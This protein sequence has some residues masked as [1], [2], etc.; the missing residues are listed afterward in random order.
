MA[1]IASTKIIFPGACRGGIAPTNFQ[2]YGITADQ[3]SNMQ[4]A[5][6]KITVA[7]MASAA[8][9]QQ[10]T[11]AKRSKKFISYQHPSSLS[12]ALG[13]NDE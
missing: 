6:V 13:A 5:F 3:V 12:N 9:Q 10:F 7:V 2:Q 4:C 8:A 1:S 11:M